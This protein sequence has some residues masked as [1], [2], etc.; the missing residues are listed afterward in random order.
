MTIEELARR[1]GMTVRNVRAMQARSILAPPELKGRKGFYT[2]RHAARVMLLQRLQGRGCS[3]AAIE[4]L[5]E[6]WEAGSGLMDVMGLED[7]LRT[8]ATQGLH[9]EADV[10]TEFPELLASPVALKKALEQELVV[11]REARFIA[12]S[13]ELLDIVRRQVVAGYPLEALLEEGDA[14]LRDVDRIAAR[15]RKSFFE[16]FVDPHMAA[17]TSRRH[18]RTGTALRARRTGTES[19]RRAQPRSRRCCSSRMEP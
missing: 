13:A 2:E 10:A 4:A 16:H 3:L 14:L 9:T 18:S 8:P 1:T 11:Q 15:F 7:A 6:G 19:H 12:P 5:I 17:G